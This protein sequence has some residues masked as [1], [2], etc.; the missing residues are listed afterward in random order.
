MNLSDIHDCPQSH[1]KIVAITIDYM[2]QTS[3][4]YCH[5]KIDY[6]KW[7]NYE[8]ENNPELRQLVKEKQ[9]ET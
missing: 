5:K 2:G 7:F 9:H 1:G 3:C 4:G 6:K 8:Y